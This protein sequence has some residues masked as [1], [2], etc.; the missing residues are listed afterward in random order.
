MNRRGDV[1][2]RRCMGWH[3]RMAPIL[4]RPP[5]VRACCDRVSTLSIDRP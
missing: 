2:R 4:N 3:P 1:G 5:C